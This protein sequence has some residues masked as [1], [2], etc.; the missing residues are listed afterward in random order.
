MRDCR[1][2]G[3]RT[4]R[5]PSARP[6]FI[7]RPGSRSSSSLNQERISS[8]RAL[9]ESALIVALARAL[10]AGAPVRALTVLV[11]PSIAVSCR[12]YT[13]PLQASFS[14]CESVGIGAMGPH[15]IERTWGRPFRSI[16]PL[17]ASC[18]PSAHISDGVERLAQGPDPTRKK[19]YQTRTKTAA[20]AAAAAD[21]AA[22]PYPSQWRCSITAI[23]GSGGGGGAAPKRRIIF[24]HPLDEFGDQLGR[25]D[26][27]DQAVGVIGFRAE[28]RRAAIRAGTARPSPT[29]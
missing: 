24:V 29:C 9:E 28:L 2:R 25:P 21:A 1:R 5:T 3:S 16:R 6:T 10:A 18:V 27:L 12:R 26:Q 11:A 20:A 15:A 4:S 17:G 13:L 14:G 7:L 19:A 23:S 22:T 8:T